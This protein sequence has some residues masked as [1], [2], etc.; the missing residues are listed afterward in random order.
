MNFARWVGVAHGLRINGAVWIHYALFVSLTK[1]DL[2]AVVPYISL[3]GYEYAA[4]FLIY[5]A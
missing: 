3:L 2:L 1:E 4:P 5:T